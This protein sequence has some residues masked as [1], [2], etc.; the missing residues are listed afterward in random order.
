[1]RE[2]LRQRDREAERGGDR[3]AEEKRSISAGGLEISIKF[4]VYQ[5]LF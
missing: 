1:M 4:D 3:E 5:D 2:R